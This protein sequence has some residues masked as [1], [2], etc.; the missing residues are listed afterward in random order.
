MAKSL[1]FRAGR[2]F[3]IDQTK[4]PFQEKYIE[5]SSLNACYWAIKR[6]KVRGAP[7]LGVFASYALY[8][9]L[10]DFTGSKKMFFKKA[11]KAISTLKKSRPTAVNLFWAL[12]RIEKKIK[13]N[14]SQP[15]PVI[16]KIILSE[17]KAIHKEDIETCRRIGVNGL[18]VIRPGDSILTHCNTGFL[19]ASGE[20]TALSVIF[21]ASRKYKN[22]KVFNTE[23]RP[24]LQ[25]ARLT[26]WELLKKGLKP[27]LICDGM[28]G[29]LMQKK[30]VN[31]VITGA[32][33]IAANGDT[34]NKIGTYTLAVLAKKHNIPFYIAA[35][36]STF[37][38]SIPEGSKIPIEE[39]DSAEVKG[40][41]G[42][43]T[44]LSRVKVWNP[45]FDITPAGFITGFITD[46]GII[47]PDYKISIR[48][49]FFKY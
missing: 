4:L 1:F 48:K 17:A 43:K 38:L 29:F 27:T 5:C 37:D 14:S 7:L 26:S 47:K 34:A 45:A 15:V 22:I 39:R 25:G 16:K 44:A 19:A 41:G 24:L 30:M 21:S 42:K 6:L 31:K 32:D 33:R 9:S 13:Q 2:L 28:A 18:K 40:F 10:K 8:V 46:K 36:F 35:P 20:G 12:E 3:I 23:T 11:D 49:T